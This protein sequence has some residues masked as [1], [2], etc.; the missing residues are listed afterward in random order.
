[1][2]IIEYKNHAKKLKDSLTKSGYI[3]SLGH[4]Q[5][6]VASQNDFKSWNVL[7]AE[8]KAFVEACRLER[9]SFMKEQKEEAQRI[10]KLNKD[11]E[12][13]WKN[14]PDG[15]TKHCSYK[16]NYHTEDGKPIT[17]KKERMYDWKIAISATA[18]SM[19][20]ALRSAVSSLDDE[21]NGSSDDDFREFEH[22]LR[23]VEDDDGKTVDAPKPVELWHGTK[24]I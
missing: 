8:Q 13:F 5:E 21:V 22:E 2:L 11:K 20:E 12:E 18:N 23:Y 3:V 16:F 6:A 17:H 10:D 1:M 24:A 15:Y 9:E 4:C 7:V 14:N 19:S